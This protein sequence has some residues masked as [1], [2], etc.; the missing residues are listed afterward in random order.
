M[1]YL[2]ILWLCVFLCVFSVLCVVVC[3]LLCCM[4]VCVVWDVSVC[5]NIYIWYKCSCRVATLVC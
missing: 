3:V 5:M 1:V 4:C 2:C